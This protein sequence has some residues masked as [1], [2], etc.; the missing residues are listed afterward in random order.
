VAH[1]VGD[2]V[3]MTIDGFVESRGLLNAGHAAHRECYT[4][5]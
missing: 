5:G 2:R 3:M 4:N 1:F